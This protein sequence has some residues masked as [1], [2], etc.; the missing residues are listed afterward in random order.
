MKLTDS[1]ST[2]QLSCDT[3]LPNIERSRVTAIRNA[4]TRN[5]KIFPALQLQVILQK[6]SLKQSLNLRESLATGIF[7]QRISTHAK[8]L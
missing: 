3:K 7:S 2:R 1:N 8:P 6:E 5:G 4:R